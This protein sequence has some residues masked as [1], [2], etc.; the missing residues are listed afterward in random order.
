MQ[1]MPREVGAAI[2]LAVIKSAALIPIL[3]SHG[4]KINIRNFL[5]KFF[6][7]SI[8]SFMKNVKYNFLREKIIHEREM[9][10]KN[11]Y[12]KN[13]KAMLTTNIRNKKV[14]NNNRII[15]DNNSNKTNQ[16]IAKIEN[17]N[18]KPNNKEQQ[19]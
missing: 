14:A 8:S 1:R 15:L 4:V 11:K 9:E 7:S 19:Q 12:N 2:T 17:N 13:I 16:T 10:I 6:L 3:A 18:N 5:I